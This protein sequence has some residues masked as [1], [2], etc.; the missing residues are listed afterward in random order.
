MKKI[1]FID[2]YLDEWHA[3]NYPAWIE[4]YNR[5]HGTDFK[6]AFAF[7]EKEV[8]PKGGLSS[9]EWCAR[10]GAEECRSIEEVCEKSDF[11]MILAPSDPEK[12][13]GYCRKS[14]SLQK[15]RLRRQD[16]CARLSFGR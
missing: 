12:H 11:I 7:A 8:P 5:K 14:F 3:N 13:L 9:S 1:G 15:T 4:E 6:V 16:V 10:F 2:Y